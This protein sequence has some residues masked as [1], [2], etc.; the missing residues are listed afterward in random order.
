MK[1]YSDKKGKEHDE[2]VDHVRGR[3][4]YSSYDSLQSIKKRTQRETPRDREESALYKSLSTFR[5][6]LRSVDSGG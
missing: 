3:V 5:K 6:L 2:V 1:R 4:D